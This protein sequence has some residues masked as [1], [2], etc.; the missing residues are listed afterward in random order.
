MAAHCGSAQQQDHT[1]NEFPGLLVV[2]VTIFALPEFI[3]PDGVS[4]L[5]QTHGPGEYNRI[6]IIAGDGNGPMMM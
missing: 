3:Q 6:N 1:R 5:N 2:Q 4:G